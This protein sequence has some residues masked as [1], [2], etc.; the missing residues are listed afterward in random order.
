MMAFVLPNPNPHPLLVPNLHGLLLFHK[1][2]IVTNSLLQLHHLLLDQQFCFTLLGR[3]FPSRPHQVSFP[4]TFNH[5][6]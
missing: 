6:A 5:A 2:I 1:K 4:S 3:Y